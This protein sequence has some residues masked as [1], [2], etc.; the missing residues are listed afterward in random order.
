[1]YFE[2]VRVTASFILKSRNWMIKT[3]LSEMNFY[4]PE[5]CTISEIL[6]Y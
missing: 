1:M 6:S 4:L 3:L 5:K 2:A